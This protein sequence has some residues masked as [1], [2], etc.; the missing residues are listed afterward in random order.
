MDTNIA[1]RL[2]LIA[3]LTL[4]NAFFAS[5]EMAIV[6]VNKNKMQL[7]WEQ[8]GNRK[9]KRLVEM[10][11]S[12]SGFLAT[13]QVGITLAG[14]FSS[15]FAATGISVKLA[16]AMNRLNIP[17]SSQL[18]IIIVTVLLSY[19][20]LVFGE[21]VPKRLALHRTEEIALF[22]SRYVEMLSKIA[23]PFVFILTKSTNLVSGIFG[24]G[25]GEE[26][27]NISEDEIRLLLK[28]GLLQGNIKYMEKKMIDNVFQFNDT[29]AGEAMTSKV[30]VFMV[31][32]EMEIKDIMK[33]MPPE[34][35]SRIPVYENH[36]DNIIGILLLKDVLINIMDEETDD[37][38]I[39]DI[40]H[41]PF[42]VEDTLPV[43]RLFMRMQ[44]TGNHMAVIA[45]HEG[46]ITGIITIEDLI[47][48]IMGEIEDEFD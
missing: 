41:K 1:G 26:D 17:Y 37:P 48:E 6:S 44:R 15:A 27:E 14:F 42:I 33:M 40:I 11:E 4:V 24:A 38:K 20:M 16:P 25:E 31:D 7:E 3:L 18:S 23:K 28:K 12:P 45:N 5:A 36:R 47:E 19:F 22:S 32:V 30:D 8:K 9:A 34:T 2:I 29:T 39:R 21:L 46:T 13:I 10:L 35:Y 43:N